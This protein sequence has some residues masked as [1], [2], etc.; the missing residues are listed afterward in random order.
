MMDIARTP[1]VD[2]LPMKPPMVFLDRVVSYEDEKLTTET[3]VRRENPFCEDDGMPGWVGIEYM[4][5]SVAAYSGVQA[6]IRGDS[7]SVGFLLGTRAYEC[8]VSRFPL[9]ETLTILV[10]QLFSESGLGA[11]SCSILS[12]R[13]V[14]SATINV[15][16]PDKDSLEDFWAGKL[17]K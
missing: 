6:C 5:Q 16:Q 11:F 8:A 3:T 7:P 15:Y 14:A 1:I 12:D 13:P 9:G 10:E 4:A 17:S 2:F